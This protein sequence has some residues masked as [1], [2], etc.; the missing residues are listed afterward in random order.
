M[1]FDWQSN[2]VDSIILSVRPINNVTVSWEDWS[3]F[4]WQIERDWGSVKCCIVD[5]NTQP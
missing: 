5:L 1:S 3:S 4:E 2:E